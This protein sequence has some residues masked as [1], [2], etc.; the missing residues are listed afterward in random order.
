MTDLSILERRVPRNGAYCTVCVDGRGG[1]GKSTLATALTAR[2]P[3]FSL[4]HGDDY[5]EPHGQPVTWADFNE[6]RLDADVLAPMRA[7]APSFTVRPYDFEFSL[8][9]RETRHR[10][11][12]RHLRA[13]LRLLLAGVVGP[14]DLSRGTARRVLRTWAR[15]RWWS[16][17][18]T[19]TGGLGGVWQPRD[20]E[21]IRATAP[22]RRADIIVDGTPPFE[23]QFVK[24]SPSDG[25][26]GA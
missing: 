13:R 23:D 21:Y 10:S 15:A 12:G 16:H 6:I 7:G 1:S 20:E 8:V 24:L 14:H 18:P 9:A 17:G 11:A 19:G 4:V 25:E 3:G 22:R 2:L 26:C 5:F